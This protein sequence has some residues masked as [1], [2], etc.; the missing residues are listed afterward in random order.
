MLHRVAIALA[1]LASL[2]APAFATTYELVQLGVLPGGVS[3]TATAVN[4]NGDV[5]G[6]TTL[7]GGATQ[8]FIWTQANGMQAIGVSG[9]GNQANGINDSDNVVGSIGNQAFRWDS[10][11]GTVL[12]DPLF[13]GSALGINDAGTVVGNRQA[14]G[15]TD[16]TLVWSPTNV[17]SNPFSALDTRA[18]A[19]NSSGEYVGRQTSGSGGYY[20]NGSVFAS[21]G[22][23]TPNG[24]SDNLLAVGALVAIA[25]VRNIQPS[26]DTTIGTLSG[27]TTSSALGINP[28]G[29][30]VVGI[31]NGH[32]GFVYDVASSSLQSLTSLLA[33][34]SS[35]FTIST[36]TA[37]NNS[38]EIAAVGVFSGHPEAVLLVPTPEPSSLFL[39]AL[40]AASLFLAALRRD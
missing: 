1:L 24:L 26:I 8:A 19:I 38:G 36:A 4:S 28:L 31:S 27:D 40:G 6:Y 13:H 39:A 7:P 9:T 15:S 35:N 10:V 21:L 12:L 23:F 3:S 2:C 14:G 34:D 37:V 17:E 20:D 29:T 16:R 18:V 5:A 33:P 30:E 22:S 25:D 32:G 11:N